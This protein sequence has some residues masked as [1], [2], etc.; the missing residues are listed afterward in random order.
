MLSQYFLFF[1]INLEYQWA[2]HNLKVFLVLFLLFFCRNIGLIRWEFLCV[3]VCMHV[4]VCVC[5]C[6]CV[7]VCAC[8]CKRER[9]SPH[10]LHLAWSLQR[11]WKK[12]WLRTLWRHSASTESLNF[13]IESHEICNQED[14]IISLCHFAY[15]MDKG[16][17]VLREIM[18]STFSTGNFFWLS[19]GI[20]INNLI[21]VLW[22]KPFITYFSTGIWFLP[23]PFG[24]LCCFKTGSYFSNFFMFWKLTLIQRLV[25][26]HVSVVTEYVS[27]YSMLIISISLVFCLH[28]YK[29]HFLFSWL[30]FLACIAPLLLLKQNSGSL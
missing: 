9:D 12:S 20:S 13:H 7:C 26:L 27:M 4:C 8:A 16:I 11:P 18:L 10:L 28:M 3:C 24:T 30:E 5:A 15:S 21:S 14:L 23:R 22:S 19:S 1:Y 25:N 2:A 6:A 17:F 29:W